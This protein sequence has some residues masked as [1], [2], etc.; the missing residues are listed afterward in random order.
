[1]PWEDYEGGKRG[2]LYLSEEDETRVAQLQG[3]L[4]GD[5]DRSRED[6]GWLE[7]G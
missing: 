3:S 6:N 5:E 7:Y 4:G 2:V 1:M